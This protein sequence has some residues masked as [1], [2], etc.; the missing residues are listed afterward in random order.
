MVL[1]KQNYGVQSN[2]LVVIDIVQNSS[3]FNVWIESRIIFGCKAC[4]LVYVRNWLRIR[5]TFHVV[6]TYVVET[7]YSGFMRVG[8]RKL[9]VGGGVYVEFCKYS[10]CDVCIK[11]FINR[12]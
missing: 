12:N 8:I 5:V 2:I 1:I 6:E 3:L 10:L 4:W 11:K 9:I 7:V